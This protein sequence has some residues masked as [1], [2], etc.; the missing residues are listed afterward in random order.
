MNIIVRYMRYISTALIWI[1]IFG[2]IAL[3]IKIIDM[4]TN[5]IIKDFSEAKNIP[6]RTIIVIVGAIVVFCVLISFSYAVAGIA[7]W[8]DGL[9][10]G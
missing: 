1:L 8:C 4:I 9:R 2:I 7:E 6:Q 10:L 5:V 3:G